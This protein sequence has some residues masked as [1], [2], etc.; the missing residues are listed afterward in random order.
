MIDQRSKSRVLEPALRQSLRI[1]SICLITLPLAGRL[2]L[3]FR[4]PVPT[5]RLRQKLPGLRRR[6]M[7]VRLLWPISSVQFP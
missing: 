1:S 7:L 6:T 5:N 4:H 3:P 2:S